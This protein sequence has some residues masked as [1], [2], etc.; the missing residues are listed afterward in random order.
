MSVRALKDTSDRTVAPAGVISVKETRD[1]FVEVE[2]TGAH[3]L[4]ILVRGGL[5]IPGNA[6]VEIA[7]KK[8]SGRGRPPVIKLSPA[9]ATTVRWAV[10]ETID[11]AG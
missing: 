6:V 1:L 2:M 5:K 4:E 11:D 10:R 3:L 8:S 9:E 7:I